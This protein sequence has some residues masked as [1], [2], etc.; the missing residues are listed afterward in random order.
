MA[1]ASDR[2]AV[3]VTTLGVGENCRVED[4]LANQRL[5]LHDLAVDGQRGERDRRGAADGRQGLAALCCRQLCV[6]VA[7]VPGDA[8]SAEEREEPRDRLAVV[9]GGQIHSGQDP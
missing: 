2:G 7:C 5:G 9:T 3:A 8:G 4:R 6:E 1:W